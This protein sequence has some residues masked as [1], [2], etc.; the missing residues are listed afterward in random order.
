MPQSDPVPPEAA[1]EEEDHSYDDVIENSFPASDPPPGVIKVGPRHLPAR[2]GGA[3]T[4]E[5]RIA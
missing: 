5:R 2:T 4:R 3:Q 1:S